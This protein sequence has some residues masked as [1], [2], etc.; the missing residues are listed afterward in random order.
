MALCCSCWSCRT[1][2]RCCCCCRSTSSLWAHSPAK[3]VPNR[4][5]LACTAWRWRAQPLR[6]RPSRSLWNASHPWGGSGWWVVYSWVYLWVVYHGWGGG[7]S[8]RQAKAQAALVGVPL[9]VDCMIA[10]DGDGW[11]RE[12]GAVGSRLRGEGRAFTRGWIASLQWMVTIRTGKKGR[13]AASCV[14]RGGQGRSRGP[15]SRAA[16]SAPACCCFRPT[17]RPASCSCCTTPG[18]R[19]CP[20][21]LLPC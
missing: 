1:R 13:W 5:S 4:A 2:P 7:S 10:M 21:H 14:G 6:M 11:R 8:T 17:R 12:E 3:A 16:P 18:P 19:R 9:W 15:D 20:A